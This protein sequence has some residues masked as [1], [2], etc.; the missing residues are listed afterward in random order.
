VI[1]G[2]FATRILGL[3]GGAMTGLA[4]GEE[5][6]ELTIET[7]SILNHIIKYVQYRPQGRLPH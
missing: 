4:A 7:K 6:K 1:S 2:N 5:K 3:I